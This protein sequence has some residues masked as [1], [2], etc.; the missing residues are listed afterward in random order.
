MVKANI[1]GIKVIVRVSA[2]FGRLTGKSAIFLNGS[3]N[4]LA[5]TSLIESMFAKSDCLK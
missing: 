1:G 3:V 5:R 2:L 4:D